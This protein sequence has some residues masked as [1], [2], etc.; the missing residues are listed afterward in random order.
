M[1]D[2]HK[3]GDANNN[4]LL[5]M[6]LGIVFLLGGGGLTAFAILQNKYAFLGA[7]IPFILIGIF[8]I[9][10]SILRSKIMKKAKLLEADG[11]AFIAKAKFVKATFS[12]YTAKQSSIGGVPISGDLKVY[13]KI[14]YTYVDQNGVAQKGKS[15]F[16]YTDNQV[17]YLKSLGEF[18]IKCDGKFSVI[19]QEIPDTQSLIKFKH[20]KIEHD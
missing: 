19:I 14:H 7:A 4:P 10:F 20:G 12:G 3:N 5:V 1:K 16:S 11:N 17:R 9:V 8:F 6:I 18:D 2:K 15:I 13:K